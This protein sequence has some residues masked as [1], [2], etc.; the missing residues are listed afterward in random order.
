MIECPQ[1]GYR[2]TLSNRKIADLCKSHF[3]D[4]PIIEMAHRKWINLNTFSVEGEYIWRD[5][6]ERRFLEHI[7]SELMKFF[8]VSTVEELKAICGWDGDLIDVV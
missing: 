5:G 8:S 2:D 7:L 1:C 4:A 3:P 6:D